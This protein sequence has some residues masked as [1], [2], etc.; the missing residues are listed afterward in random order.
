MFLRIV[1]QNHVHVTHIQG[2]SRQATPIFDL[3]HDSADRARHL[4]SMMQYRVDHQRP[5]VPGDAANDP[6]E[7]IRIPWEVGFP[8]QRCCPSPGESPELGPSANDVDEFIAELYTVRRFHGFLKNAIRR[9][10]P[11]RQRRRN[12]SIATHSAERLNF[13]TWRKAQPCGLPWRRGP[14]C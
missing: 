14:A 9:A 2:R 8:W 12:P 10:P 5:A 11:S 1:R 13:F 6:P 7:E 4:L 3:H